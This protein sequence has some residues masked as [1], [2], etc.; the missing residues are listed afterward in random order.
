MKALTIITATLAAGLAAAFVGGA[1]WGYNADI[2]S[3]RYLISNDVVT[4]AGAVGGAV[5]LA[6]AAHLFRRGTRPS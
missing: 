5:F 4:A 3:E 6:L 2:D 1:V